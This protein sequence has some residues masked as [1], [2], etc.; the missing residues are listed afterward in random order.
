ML[1]HLRHLSKY[2]IF[3][4]DRTQV[5]PW[6]QVFMT[7]NRRGNTVVKDGR[8]GKAADRER[9]KSWKDDERLAHK[10]G[11]LPGPR[12]TDPGDN[13]PPTPKE[14]DKIYNEGRERPDMGSKTDD[15]YRCQFKEDQHLKTYCPEVPRGEWRR[16]GPLGGSGRPG[17]DTG[18]LDLGNKPDRR[19]PG[20][21][22]NTATGEDCRKSPFS[23][24]HRTYQED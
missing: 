14:F 6:W 2:S 17:F 20:G 9:M 5:Y 15:A 4:R 24:A 1:E 16:G 21:R 3:N 11:E 19:A 13:R 7:V 18:H 23:A 10:T 22:P 8:L 12:R